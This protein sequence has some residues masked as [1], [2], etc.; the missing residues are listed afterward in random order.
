MYKTVVKI[1]LTER[2]G[3][4]TPIRSRL[5]IIL[6]NRKK[7]CMCVHFIEFMDSMCVRVYERMSCALLNR[8]AEGK[9]KKINI[10]N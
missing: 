8:A 2:R 9:G 5:F 3:T 1:F 10:N 4:C 7:P 6:R